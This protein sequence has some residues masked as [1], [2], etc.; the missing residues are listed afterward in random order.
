MQSSPVSAFACPP[1]DEREL[2]DLPLGK[3][4]GPL[5]QHVLE[6]V[7]QPRLARGLIERADRVEQVADDDRHLPARQDQGAQTVVQSLLEHRQVADPGSGGA[8]FESSSHFRAAPHS[9]VLSRHRGAPRR[10]PLSSGSQLP[11]LVDERS[12]GEPRSRP[13][14]PV[15]HRLPANSGPIRTGALEP[16]AAADSPSAGSPGPTTG[17]DHEI[18]I[19]QDFP[20]IVDPP[21]PNGSSTRLFVSLHKPLFF[22]TL[23]RGFQGTSRPQDRLG[24]VQIP[25]F[26]QIRNE[27]RRKS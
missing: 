13:P 9:P 17:Y 26:Q 23:T 16:M 10:P 25:G 7:R 8:A 22:E 3:P 4:L 15:Y 6:E 11:G 5:E 18:A 27:P 20:P 19:L 12:A 24:K 2:V 21:N 14:K 1:R